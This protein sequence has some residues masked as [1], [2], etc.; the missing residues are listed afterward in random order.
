M[1]WWICDG[2]VVGKA[3]GEIVPQNFEVVD[4]IDADREAVFFDGQTVKLKPPKPAIDAYWDAVEWKIP[5][6][7]ASVQL[8]WQKLEAELRESAAWARAW[9]AAG[10]TVRANRAF[11]LLLSSLTATHSLT[12]LVFAFAELRSAMREQNSLTDFSLAEIDFI[13]QI[14]EA[15]GFDPAQFDLEIDNE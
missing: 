10:L 3:I 13:E 15:S 4:G 1:L 2:Q 8:N 5:L 11:T 12:D 9:G 7:S 6:R 14:L